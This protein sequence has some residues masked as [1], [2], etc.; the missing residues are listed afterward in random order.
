MK[1]ILTILTFVGATFF[2][3]TNANAQAQSQ[4]NLGLIGA[5][6]EIPVASA[7]TIAPAAFTNFDLN[8]LTLGVKGNYYFDDLF[9]LSEPWD[10]YGGANVGFGIAMNDKNGHASGIDLGLQIGGR[11]FWSDKWGVY[12]EIGGGKLGGAAYG[13]GI[14]MKM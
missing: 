9:G 4:L 11:W 2:V 13:I 7:I 1:R 8:Y 5:S 14:T 10:V 3:T 12:A 6:Y